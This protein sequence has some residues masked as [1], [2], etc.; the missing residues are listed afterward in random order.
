MTQTQ[1]D[2]KGQAPETSKIEEGSARR[3]IARRH[4]YDPNRKEKKQH[5]GGGGKGKWNDVDN[6]T[7]EFNQEEG[8]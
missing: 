8:Q 5:G 6:G 7:A 2:K 3:N 1:K 4:D